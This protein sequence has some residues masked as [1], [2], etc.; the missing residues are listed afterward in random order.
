MRQLRDVM[1]TKKEEERARQQKQQKYYNT[2]FATIGCV[3]ENQ[4]K[5]RGV[6]ECPLEPFA[7]AIDKKK[8]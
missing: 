4:L 3:T 2:N 6:V 8:G 5:R 7:E 1:K